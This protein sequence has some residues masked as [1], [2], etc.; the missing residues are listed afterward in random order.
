MG[1]AG[2]TLLGGVTIAGIHDNCENKRKEENAA[3][4]QC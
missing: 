4:E 1:I 2:V 3:E